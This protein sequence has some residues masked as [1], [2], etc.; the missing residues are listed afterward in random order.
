[1]DKIYP[2]INSC[3]SLTHPIHTLLLPHLRQNT[4]HTRLSRYVSGT[5]SGNRGGGMGGQPS[6]R[7]SRTPSFQADARSKLNSSSRTPSFNRT[8][9]GYEATRPT[10]AWQ[11]RGDRNRTS[12]ISEKRPSISAGVSNGLTES[13][14]GDVNRQC[15]L[16][17]GFVIRAGIS[18][19]CQEI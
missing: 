17:R 6:S 13:N 7:S 14:R 10:A 8:T 1:M 19:K 3:Q 9:L 16:V 12:S 5:D 2:F 4:A 15:S 18:D 11:Q